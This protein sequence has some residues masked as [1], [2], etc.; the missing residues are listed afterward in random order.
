MTGDIGRL[1]ADG[2][3]YMLDR[4]DDMVISGGFNIYPAELENMI[5]AHPDVVAVA[6]LGIVDERWDEVRVKGEAAVTE[7]A[8]TQALCRSPWQ[9]QAGR[10][11]LVASRSIA[12]D[13]GRQD[14]AQE[15][16]DDAGFTGTFRPAVSSRTKCAPGTSRAVLGQSGAQGRRQL[17]ACAAR[18]RE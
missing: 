2:Y 1:D 6:V 9:L 18:L 5:A 4:A 8:T 3:L 15:R 14:Q 11:S 12:Q 13:V 7:R 17:T 16:T 10:Q